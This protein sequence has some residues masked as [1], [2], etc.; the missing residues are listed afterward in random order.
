MLHNPSFFICVRH[1]LNSFINSEV[2]VEIL[3]FQPLLIIVSLMGPKIVCITGERW[4]W[5]VW[6]TKERAHRRGMVRFNQFL[7][8]NPSFS[9]E[10]LHH[11]NHQH[12]DHFHL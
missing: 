5:T 8:F 9:L 11:P 3:V 7:S 1:L 10:T 6:V 2:V 12:E 4:F